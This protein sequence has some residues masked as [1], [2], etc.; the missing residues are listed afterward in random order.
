MNGKSLMKHHCLKKNDLHS[1]LNMEDITDS[2]H[3][4]AKRIC[5]DFDIKYLGEYHGFYLKSDTYYWLM[6]L[7]FAGKC[8]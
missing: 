4:H 5:K 1:N 8:I 6:F 7:K 3:I 2:D